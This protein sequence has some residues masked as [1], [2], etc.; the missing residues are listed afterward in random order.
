MRITDGEPQASMDDITPIMASSG[1]VGRR[2]GV[3]VMPGFGR[4]YG[5]HDD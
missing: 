4:A 5:R 3:N 1:E 2:S